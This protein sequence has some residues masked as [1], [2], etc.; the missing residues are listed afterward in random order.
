MHLKY[1]SYIKTKENFQKKYPK[2]SE[3]QRKI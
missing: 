2:A 1:Y 3:N